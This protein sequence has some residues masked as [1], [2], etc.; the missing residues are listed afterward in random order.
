MK[1]SASFPARLF[2]AAALFA[3]ASLS[4]CASGL[5]QAQPLGHAAGSENGLTLYGGYRAGGTLT[6]TTTGQDVRVGSHASFAL[7]LD[8]SL[9]PLKQLQLFYS[10]QKTDLSSGAFLVSTSSIPL[11]IEYYHLGGTA[12][13]ESM[14]NGPYVVG[15]IGATVFRPEGPGLTSETKPSINVGF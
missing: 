4:T 1:N 10:R 8:I 13:F 12:F 3:L 15:G 7:A 6:E 14:S 9:E 2:R 11:T 5:A